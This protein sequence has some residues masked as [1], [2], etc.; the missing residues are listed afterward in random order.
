DW[1]LPAADHDA[2]HR[3]SRI[4]IDL[5]VRNEWR[6]VDEISGSGILD[7]FQPVAPPESRAAL[8]YV[9]N[10]LEIAMMMS[11]GLCVRLHDNR[12]RPPFVG[13]RPRVRNGRGAS[14]AGCLRRVA[15]Q[16]ASPDDPDAML[17]PIRFRFRAHWVR[18]ER[19]RGGGSSGVPKS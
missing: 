15:V 1:L 7:E 5:L 8:H 11:A 19:A 3:I 13:A 10:G 14:H 2:L 16:L 9:K 6:H 17:F 4:G 18:K 12:A